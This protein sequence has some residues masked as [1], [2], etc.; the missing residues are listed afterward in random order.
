MDPKGNISLEGM[1]NPRK[2]GLIL[3]VAL[4]CVC[5]FVSVAEAKKKKKNIGVSSKIGQVGAD[6]GLNLFGVIP[7]GTMNKQKGEVDE[8]ASISGTGGIGPYLGLHGH[9]MFSGWIVRGEFGYGYQGGT[10][11]AN[12]DNKELED[13]DAE[14][15]LNDLRIGAG[16][17]KTL[18]KH[19]I[20]HPYLIGVLDYHYL[21]FRD[22]DWQESAKGSGVGIGALVGVDVM[23][24]KHFFAGAGVRADM[25]YSL[26]P[27]K[28]E[29]KGTTREIKMGYVPFTLF[30]T[31][32]LMF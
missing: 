26:N 21:T 8:D 6:V 22:K 25:I 2:M 17:G 9:L 20:I 11:K 16:F 15:S 23:F 4:L 32:G 1:M 5:L 27:L 31:G 24:L 13:D 29:H 7:Y 3:I 14:F 19:R 12:Y 18:V 30:F 28:L 10:F